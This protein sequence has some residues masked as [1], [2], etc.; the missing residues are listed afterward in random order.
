M[1]KAPTKRELDSQKKK[2]HIYNSAISLFRRYGFEK[3][4]IQDIAEASGM[5]SGSIYN[6]FGSKEGILDSTIESIRT[7]EI[8]ETEWDRKV[9]DPYPVL[10]DHFSERARI[11]D[12]FGP[13]L[14]VHM[15]AEYRRKRNDRDGF[16]CTKEGLANLPEFIEA[17]QNAGTFDDIIS[18]HYAANYLLC[19]ARGLV[20]EWCDFKGSYDFITRV[21]A[22]MPRVINSFLPYELRRPD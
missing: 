22:F 9:E 17:C 21:R 13:D 8:P 12:E 7:V 5:S 16:F 2:R 19:A 1:V 20:L 14:T 3:T 18:P 11:W 10:L 6:F 15:A 4:T